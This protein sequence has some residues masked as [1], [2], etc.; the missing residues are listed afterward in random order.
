[1]NNFKISNFTL[2]YINLITVKRQ[3][4]FYSF[5]YVL[6]NLATYKARSF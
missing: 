3:L 6:E 4:F 2:A 1:M 5:W